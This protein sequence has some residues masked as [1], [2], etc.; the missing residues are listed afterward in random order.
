MN[1]PADTNLTDRILTNIGELENSGIELSLNA[2]VVDTQ[3]FLLEHRLD[4]A[5]NKNKALAIDQISNQGVLT[6]RISGNFV[7]ILQVGQPVNSFYVFQ[8]LYGADGSPLQDGIDHND[9]GT[10]NL[11]DIYADVNG[12][13]YERPRQTPV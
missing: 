11:A 5:R 8:Q 7:Q 2:F 3:R 4:A 13:V 1:I 10:V 6:G 9:D 12:A